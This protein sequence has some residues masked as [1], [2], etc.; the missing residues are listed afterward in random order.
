[1]GLKPFVSGC[2]AGEY[3]HCGSPAEHKVQEM[4]MFDDYS[5]RHELMTYVCHFH[6]RQMMGPAA[7][8]RYMVQE[9]GS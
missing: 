1:M 5:P 7:D 3:C 9:R 4:I 2:C 6:F 8:N